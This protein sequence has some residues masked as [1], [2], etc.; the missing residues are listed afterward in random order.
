MILLE[1]NKWDE[2]KPSESMR[3][4]ASDRFITSQRV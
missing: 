3:V 2:W 4:R 1:K